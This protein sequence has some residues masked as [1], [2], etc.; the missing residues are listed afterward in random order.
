MRDDDDPGT[1]QTV[2]SDL[3]H[4]ATLAGDAGAR[5]VAPAPPGIDD[6]G[7][8][9][10]VSPGHF[11]RGAT[12]ARGGMGRIVIARDRRIGRDV[13]IKELIAPS[14]SARQRFERE[15]RITARLQHPAIVSLHEAGTWPSGEPF[16]AMKLV[17]GRPLDKVIA[18]A[19][20]PAA[21]IALLPHG[22][23]VADALAYAHARR[24]IHRDLKPANVLV[25]D[26]G[27]TVVID[28]GLAKDLTTAEVEVSDPD[29][30]RSSDETAFGSV[31][32]T[33]AYMPPEQ[34]R[35]ETVDERADVYAIG[36]LLYHLLGGKPPFTG[37]S[38]DEVLE[39][40]LRERARPLPERAPEVPRD[41]AAIV[42]KAM[43]RDPEDRYPTAGA[44]AD[45]LRRFQAGQLVGAHHYTIGALLGR[46][47][48]RHRA[49]IGVS[50]AALVVLAVLAIVGVRRVVAERDAA[51]RAEQVAADERAT[52]EA[53]RLEAETQ[54]TASEELVGFMLGDL[55]PQLQ[56]VGRL[57]LLRGVG[58]RVVAYYQRLPEG[59]GGEAQRAAALHVL[60]EVDDAAGDLEGARRAYQAALALR[61]PLAA[62]GAP[63]AVV[64]LAR[65]RLMLS[66]TLQQ[67]GDLD[68]ALREATAA[69]DALEPMTGRSPA[70][71]VVLAG[72]WRRLGIVATMRGDH[73]EAAVAL[74]RCLE[75][76]G[77]APADRNARFE[78]SK[79]HDRLADVRWYQ[80]DTKA[81][82]A[83]VDAGRQLREAMLAADPGDLEVQHAL[84]V[85]WDKLVTLAIGDND[86]AAADQAAAAEVALVEPLAARDP[87]NFE[88]GRA[89]VVALLRPA[90]IAHIRDQHAVAVSW[91]EKALVIAER[92][93]AR[94]PDSLD[95]LS[96]LSMVLE[97]LASYLMWTQQPDRALE[98]AR[99]S[100][101]VADAI[102]AK[103]PDNQT[104]VAGAAAAHQ[105]LAHLLMS[106]G[107][108]AG[109]A[110]EYHHH[111]E[112]LDAMLATD[113]TS[114]A[115]QADAIDA[116]YFE[117][118]ALA[119][120]AAR[121]DEGIAMMTAALAGLRELAAAGKLTQQRVDRLPEYEADLAETRR[122]GHAP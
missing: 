41:L 61:E 72:A 39:R 90:E 35:G 49:V 87:D 83:E 36:A 120:I 38:S 1:D 115:L 5:S 50:A 28:W 40:V 101:E 27:E 25:G 107:D 19:E 108:Y 15:A 109:A 73:D 16:Y 9:V 103:V 26:Y 60:G 75:R 70:A 57:D 43:A 86:L 22:I 119:S 23:A 100:V 99:R 17:A 81:G 112:G 10:A 55:Q 12:V 47:V 69:R 64:A 78:A 89:F 85:S 33:P 30:N 98:V 105:S 13:A 31:L 34:A 95:R 8:L 4:T 48:R 68:G 21:R 53:R 92:Q 29:V 18:A 14:P 52:A 11:V 117:G 74:A 93:A 62:G 116:R 97:R 59:S 56:R 118:R 79:C 121:H 122:L 76:A 91:T 42:A 20:T 88:W 2:A 67:Q 51:R 3:G 96:D 80:G 66:I 77:E 37:S 84:S 58:A 114:P 65:T 71:V 7:A 46:W 104:Y 113:Q 106:S 32:G 82:H 45:D 54:R 102:R 24:V 111:V 110:A 6:Y 44:L 94:F 63:D